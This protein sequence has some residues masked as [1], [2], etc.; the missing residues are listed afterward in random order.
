MR[1]TEDQRALIEE[2][3]D[4]PR[5]AVTGYKRKY[6]QALDAFDT[7]LTYE[8]ALSEATIGLVR[9]AISWKPER[10]SFRKWASSRCFTA[11]IDY[12]RTAGQL[13]RHAER[14]ENGEVVLDEYGEPVRRMRLLL[15][16]WQEPS[17]D[18][19]RGGGHGT[20]AWL[21][22]RGQYV[23]SAEDETCE[24]VGLADLLR[25]LP[26]N[27]RRVLYRYF[28]QGY[29][30]REIGLELGLTESRAS[31]LKTQGEARLWDLGIRG[32]VEL[33]AA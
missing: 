10:G 22:A 25:H 13:R 27:E 30:L 3:S 4:L 20:E 21:Y 7:Q 14:D 32:D 11:V 16:T 8:D 18:P 33:I 2:H 17:N 29:T 24:L 12:T 31:Q 6:P 23:P 5:I 26:E 28:G 15:T 9:A 19:D 1:L